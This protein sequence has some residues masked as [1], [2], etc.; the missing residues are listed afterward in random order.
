MLH[1]NHM[2][3]TSGRKAYFVGYIKSKMLIFMVASGNEAF[4]SW[5][6]DGKSGNSKSVA[7]I[8]FR[9]QIY[10]THMLLSSQPEK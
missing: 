7:R 5:T 6:L 2:S 4:V 3:K 9:I 8:G 10:T 1:L